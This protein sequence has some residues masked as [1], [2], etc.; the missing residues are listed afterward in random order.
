MNWLCESFQKNQ[1]ETDEE[2]KQSAMYHKFLND[3][4]DENVGNFSELCILIIQRRDI[5]CLL[6]GYCETEILLALHELHV[7]K[8]MEEDL[9][10]E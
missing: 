5:K 4:D 8:G 3:L 2:S 1:N 9:L 10:R 7:K 6:V